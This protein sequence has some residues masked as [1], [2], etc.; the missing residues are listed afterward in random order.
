MFSRRLVTV[1]TCMAVFAALISATACGST[2]SVSSTATVPSPTS[3]STATSTTSTAA[4]ATT[5]DTAASTSGTVAFSDGSSTTLAPELQKYLDAMN[6]FGDT[7]SNAPDNSFLKITDPTTATAADI[8]RADDAS[9]FSHKAQDQLL[10]IKAPALVAALHGKVVSAFQTEVTT[11]DEF[12]GALKSKDAAKMKSA[13]DALVQ[14]AD[15]LTTLVNQVM[16][17]AGGQ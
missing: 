13:H 11:M 3:A 6:A 7:F 9:I 4:S 12:I 16:A 10:A 1:A 8:K 5:S 17:A 2:T 14:Q 15:D